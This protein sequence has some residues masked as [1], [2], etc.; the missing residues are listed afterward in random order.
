MA[1]LVFCLSINFR[2]AFFTIGTRLRAVGLTGIPI[3]GIPAAS[4]IAKNVLE[5]RHRI[6]FD[7]FFG[8]ASRLGRFCVARAAFDRFNARARS[9]VGRI[10]ATCRRC[11]IGRVRTARR[12]R[13][14]SRVCAGR[15]SRICGISRI[16]RISRNRRRAEL[17]D[18]TRLRVNSC[19]CFASGQGCNINTRCNRRTIQIH[20]DTGVKI[21]NRLASRICH[22]AIG[23]NDQI[24]ATRVKD[25]CRRRYDSLCTSVIGNRGYGTARSGIV[26][27]SANHG[28][29][30]G[31]DHRLE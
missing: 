5:C 26:A 3:T 25:P 29:R 18:G 1:G 30:T 7:I 27:A 8:V 2:L 10:R 19:I 24:S 16:G 6:Q 28:D 13:R 31:R 12:R 15:R 21:A 9:R 23:I 20:N 4:T 11:R 17:F 14:I 22:I